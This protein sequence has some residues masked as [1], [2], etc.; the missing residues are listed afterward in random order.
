M[1]HVD[2]LI[3]GGGLVGGTLACALLPHGIKVG[4]VDPIDPR[5]ARNSKDIRT[6]AIALGSKIIL[7]T[8]GLWDDVVFAPSPIKSIRISQEHSRTTLD[9]HA[10]EVGA[11]AMGY[12]VSNNHLRGAIGDRLKTS[13]HVH[14]FT[15]DHVD[16]IVHDGS[17]VFVHLHSGVVVKTKLVVGADGRHS[18]MRHLKDFSALSWGEDECAI[19]ALLA[20]EKPHNHVAIE[21]FLTKG[22]IALLPMADNQSTLVWSM[23]CT[24]SDHIARLSDNDFCTLVAQRLQYTVGQMKLAS[25]RATHVLKRVYVPDPTGERTI[26]VGDAAHSIHPIAGQ[27]LNLGIRDVA[28][29]AELLVQSKQLG[30]DMGRHVLCQEY[31]RWRTSDTMGLFM[32]TEGILHAFTNKSNVLRGVRSFGMRAIGR[33][34]AIKQ[35]MVRQA[36]GVAGDLPK[37]ARGEIF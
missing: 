1:I 36:M 18:Y 15:P 2:V 28:I 14:L 35:G 9:F 33:I 26:L 5:E 16:H 17:W 7:D 13:P 20:H 31:R 4:V 30:L 3:L 34:P 6:S 32:T 22:P 24:D 11:D 10:S 29:L 12:I 19:V 23:K 25:R 21:H 8:L 27:G 37:L